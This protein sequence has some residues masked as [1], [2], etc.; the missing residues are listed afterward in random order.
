MNRKGLK[1]CICGPVRNCG[2]Y[3]SQVLQNIEKIGK[4][5]EEYVIIISYDNSDDN[6]LEILQ[7]YQKK[8]ERLKLYINTG[9]TS[10]YRTHNIAFA[11]NKC[12]ELIRYKYR[13]YPFFIMMDFDDVNAKR[14]NPD[15][16][17]KYLYRRDWD[18]LSFQTT[19]AYY[20]IWALSIPPYCFSYNHFQDN[21]KQY[22]V[23]QKYVTK[24]LLNMRKGDLLRCLSAFNGFAI[25]RSR[26]FLHCVYDGK[27]RLDL[28][29]PSMI[30]A[31]SNAT[32]SPLIYKDY[33]NVHG[34]FEDCEHRSFHLMAQKRFNA[35]IMIA[36]DV[37][38]Y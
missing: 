22:N 33:G 6:S 14:V 21:V 25:Y 37:V 24:K 15:V 32:N 10:K 1:C 20:D 31:H 28:A 36:R 9:K 13:H 11:R 12:L 30:N 7:E 8:D 3:L 35:Q 19:P 5:F 4:L 18:S 29:T 26:I 16:L 34:Q 23:I 2:K 38:F 27:V 17:R